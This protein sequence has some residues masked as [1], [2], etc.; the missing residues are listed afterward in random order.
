MASVGSIA[1]LSS[2]LVST[3]LNGPSNA[4]SLNTTDRAV[5]PKAHEQ[6]CTMEDR[7]IDEGRYTINLGFTWDDA[8]T[9]TCLKVEQAMASA[10][11]EVRILAWQCKPN[12][13]KGYATISFDC[14]F[15]KGNKINQLLDG[16]FA[17]GDLMYTGFDCLNY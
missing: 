1:S 15:G 12:T 8:A 6:S 7:D 17:Q 14:V 3:P 2:D 5:V 4:I 16:L 11:S 9:R 10:C 13:G